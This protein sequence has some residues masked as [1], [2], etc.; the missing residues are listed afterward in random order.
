MGCYCYV[1][2]PLSSRNG[3]YGVLKPPYQQGY[4]SA[5]CIIESS[6][7]H[8]LF[9]S[10][11]LMKCTY[12][13]DYSRSVMSILYIYIRPS[14]SLKSE[15][16]SVKCDFPLVVSECDSETGTLTGHDSRDFY[17]ISWW[18][19]F[20]ALRYNNWSRLLFVEWLRL[21]IS[22]ITWRRSTYGAVE[23]A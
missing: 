14:C 8:Y 21:F 7:I 2:T 17:C 15:I 10:F 1:K 9:L 5:S 16:R 12:A 18:L 6:V 22:A 4:K 19:L 13:Y 11:P 23:T 20:A 3:M